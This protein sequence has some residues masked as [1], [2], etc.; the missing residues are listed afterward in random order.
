[1]EYTNIKAVLT[2]VGTEQNEDNFDVY[3]FFLRYLSL[4]LKKDCYVVVKRILKYTF[5]LSIKSRKEHF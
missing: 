4:L 2:F 5:I 1:M 3:N